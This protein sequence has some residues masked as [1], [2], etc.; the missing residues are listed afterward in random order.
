MALAMTEAIVVRA[1][2]RSRSFERPLSVAVSNGRKLN[3]GKKRANCCDMPMAASFMLRYLDLGIAKSF[4]DIFPT[5][6]TS[7]ELPPR[8]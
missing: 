8:K 1:A 3:S 7:N 5:M 2:R 6:N 4:D